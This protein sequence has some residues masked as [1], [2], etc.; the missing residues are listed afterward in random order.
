MQEYLKRSCM[1]NSPEETIYNLMLT[2][3][4]LGL[5]NYG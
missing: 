3:L 5:W 2:V 1:E 4:A